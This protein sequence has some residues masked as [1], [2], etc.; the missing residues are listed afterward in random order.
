MSEEFL[1]LHYTGRGIIPVLKEAITFEKYQRL[2]EYM[3][4]ESM[5]LEQK[6]ELFRQQITALIFYDLEKGVNF[7]HKPFDELTDED[8][9]RPAENTMQWPV[10]AVNAPINAEG[11]S[12]LVK[13]A[14]DLSTDRVVLKVGQ[15]TAD[16]TETKQA[17][18]L[19]NMKKSLGTSTVYNWAPRLTAQN[20]QSVKFIPK[21]GHQ[22]SAAKKNDGYTPQQKEIFEEEAE[23]ELSAFDNGK[24]KPLY[25][26]GNYKGCRRLENKRF[27]NVALHHQ[28]KIRSGIAPETRPALHKDFTTVQGKCKQMNI[29][30]DW[31]YLSVGKLVVTLSTALEL[32]N[33]A[34]CLADHF[35]GLLNPA[36]LG[37]VSEA[38]F[39]QLRKGDVQNRL[40]STSL[41]ADIL[42]LF[43]TPSA[44]NMGKKEYT[45]WASAWLLKYNLWGPKEPD[46]VRDR[47]DIYT[48][49][50]QLPLAMQTH[51]TRYN[52]IFSEKK[53]NVS[54]NPMSKTKKP[55]F[56]GPS[57][58]G[59]FTPY[60]E[61][62]RRR[63]NYNRNR[64]NKFNTRGRNNGN[65]GRR[66]RGYRKFNPNYLGRNYNPYHQANSNRNNGD[67][68][69]NRNNNNNNY[70]NNRYQQNN[71]QNGQNSFQGNNNNRG[72]NRQNNAR[73]QNNAPPPA[74]N[75]NRRQDR[76][77]G[78]NW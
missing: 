45:E 73:T 22:E 44:Q 8:F 15:I 75:Q 55:A 39:W 43:G 52:K 30:T 74:Q 53:N 10:D 48:K 65:R 56:Q 69:N 41:L 21:Y 9:V 13:G 33:H 38:K 12:E 62:K 26:E 77:G 17:K 71:G 7:R 64:G 3:W 57:A 58:N 27:L 61:P 16:E 2:A 11:S 49:F 40:C 59:Q 31:T 19:K 5:P 66:G 6:Q 32:L 23:T 35:Y 78:N 50:E 37:P 60:G 1:K 54:G 46:R 34:N 47:R 36:K 68:N 63:N 18:H 42:H 51:W 4:D 76:R 24:D 72:D 14:S 67:R 28:L 70:Q 29:P 20:P 25:A